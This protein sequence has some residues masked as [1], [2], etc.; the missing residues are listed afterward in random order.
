MRKKKIFKK[1]D[2]SLNDM[3][4]LK[5]RTSKGLS[6]HDPSER[7]RN[8]ALVAR[9]LWECLLANDIDAFKEILRSHLEL[10]NKENL[11]KTA[12]IPRRT[13]FRMLSPSGNPTL[14]NI[15]KIIHELCA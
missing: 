5:L 1:Q 2:F 8:K 12:G 14:E 13:L 4:I 15:G 10:T 9:A 11:A 7:L 3:P 6:A